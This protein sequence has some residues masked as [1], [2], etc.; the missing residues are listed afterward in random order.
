MDREE[1][2]SPSVDHPMFKQL[3]RLPDGQTPPLCGGLLGLI[4]ILMICNTVS[5]YCPY[6]T[7]ERVLIVNGQ[8]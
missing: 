7:L 5:P 6:H 1:K 4:L 3:V 2:V 8:T